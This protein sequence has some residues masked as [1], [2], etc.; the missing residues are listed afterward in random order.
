MDAVPAGRG[1]ESHVLDEK[2]ASRLGYE[3]GHSSNAREKRSA[4]M[5]VNTNKES[6]QVTVRNLAPTPDQAQ[7]EGYFIAQYVGHPWPKNTPDYVQNLPQEYVFDH[8]IK[9]L[10]IA[11]SSTSSL[12]L[13]SVEVRTLVTKFASTSTG[14]Y[15][16]GFTTSSASTNEVGTKLRGWIVRLV[17]DGK[18][19]GVRAST[20]SY[21]ETRQG[22]SPAQGVDGNP[23]S[24]RAAQSTDGRT[25]PAVNLRGRSTPALAGGTHFLLLRGERLAE[26]T[27]HR[28]VDAESGFFHVTDAPQ[29]FHVAQDV[30]H[31]HEAAE[32][33]NDLRTFHRAEPTQEIPA[34]HLR[35]G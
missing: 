18:V 33:I 15:N 17:A 8:A 30:I 12:T 4:S 28:G 34:A 1:G 2:A 11:A 20:S 35:T 5:T 25:F 13:D 21:E 29:P 10:T 14:Y 19:L 3:Y 32:G 16:P 7:V 26:I 6:L 31:L 27:Q 24:R 23:A 22:R 9:P